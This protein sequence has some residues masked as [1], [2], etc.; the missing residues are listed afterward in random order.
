VYKEASLGDARLIFVM[1]EG[2]NITIK[3]FRFLP[4]VLMETIL[5]A[6]RSLVGSRVGGG[7]V[8]D[9]IVLRM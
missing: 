2:S 8:P 6:T 7:A 5:H 1:H 4:S 3:P 9:C